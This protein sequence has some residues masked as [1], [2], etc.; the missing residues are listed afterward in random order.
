MRN[1]LWQ[2]LLSGGERR[3]QIVMRALK[4]REGFVQNWKSGH[5]EKTSKLSDK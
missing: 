3:Q 1:I 4:L 5:Q 2:T